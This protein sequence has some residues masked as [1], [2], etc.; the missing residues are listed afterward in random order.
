MLK[1]YCLVFTYFSVVSFF[2]RKVYVSSFKR[3]SPPSAIMSGYKVQAIFY[4]IQ[5]E[6]WESKSNAADV[7]LSLRHFEW[8]N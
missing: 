4:S 3:F 1:L 6:T 5:S 7:T 2:L 8:E